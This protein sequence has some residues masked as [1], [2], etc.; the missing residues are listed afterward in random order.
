MAGDCSLLTHNTSFRSFEELDDIT[1]LWTVRHLITDLV[2]DIE[3]TG[4]PME[5]QTVSI[6]DVLLHLLIDACLV[7]HRRVGTAILQRFSSCHDIRGDITGEGTSCLYKRQ[8]ANA[9][10]SILDG[11][12]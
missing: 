3:H 6:S 7:H 4:L 9:G 2:D 1:N 12:T 8:T 5:E 10:I 11:T